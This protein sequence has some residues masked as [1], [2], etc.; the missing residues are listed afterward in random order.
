MTGI[1]PANKQKRKALVLVAYLQYISM[2]LPEN[3]GIDPFLV[4]RTQF[5]FSGHITNSRMKEDNIINASSET[6]LV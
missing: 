3:G 1:S 6:R 4:C 5:V 2:F